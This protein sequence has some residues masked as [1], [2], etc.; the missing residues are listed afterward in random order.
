LRREYAYHCAK[1]FREAMEGQAT[2]KEAGRNLASFCKAFGPNL[3]EALHEIALALEGKLHSNSPTFDAV[4]LQAWV[5][6]MVKC[7]YDYFALAR[8]PSS[9]AWYEA[10]KKECKR[11]GI[12]PPPT[13]SGAMRR[14]EKLGWPLQ[15]K[16]ERKLPRP[17][18]RNRGKIGRPLTSCHTG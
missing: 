10:V 18:E 14:L 5:E 16:R 11:K 1:L 6:E 4:Y 12:S 17:R 15:K 9:T 3:S 7:P 13:R 2:W 8:G